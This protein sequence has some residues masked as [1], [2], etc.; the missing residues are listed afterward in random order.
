MTFKTV[1]SCVLKK[2]LTKLQ[3]KKLIIDSLYSP[4]DY[5]QKEFLYRSTVSVPRL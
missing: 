2:P 1:K 3:K 5:W 4:Q